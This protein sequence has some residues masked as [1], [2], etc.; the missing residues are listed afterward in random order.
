MPRAFF[1]IGCES[2]GTKMLAEAF[3]K[4]GC[5]G[6]IGD[7]QRLD[8]L[9]FNIIPED[10]DIVFRRS[11]PHGR[12][13]TPIARIYKML[14]AHDFE[15]VPVIVQ[16]NELYTAQS[17]LARGHAITLEVAKDNVRLGREH[18]TKEMKKL[19]LNP[20]KVNYERF[21][22][23]ELV[24]K[25]FFDRYNLPVPDMEFYNANLKYA[26]I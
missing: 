7:M 25:N 2:S 12:K 6:D 15:V 16:R 21:A 19:G 14:E 9:H 13:W 22:T 26:E 17:Q 20:K 11:V 10:T 3:I 18:I 5:W 4:A 23:K 24:R 8:T 1:V